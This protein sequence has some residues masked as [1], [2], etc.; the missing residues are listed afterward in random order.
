MAALPPD[1]DEQ[2]SLEQLSVDQPKK[3]DNPERFEEMQAPE[4]PD[5]PPRPS[6]DTLPV[7]ILELIT[8]E[9][10]WPKERTPLTLVNKRLHVTVQQILYKTIV[11]Q[12]G[13][14][15]SPVQIAELLRSFTNNPQLRSIVKEIN[16]MPCN[17]FFESSPNAKIPVAG[18]HEALDEII[19][20]VGRGEAET[21]AMRVVAKAGET[22]AIMPLLFTIL[23]NLETL[24][25]NGH[26]AA[27]Q[28]ALWAFILNCLETALRS[29]NP[30]AP[31]HPFASLKHVRLSLNYHWGHNDITMGFA[32]TFLSLFY[33]PRIETLTVHAPYGTPLE[34]PGTDHLVP[35]HLRT[36]QVEAYRNDG[37]GIVK[38]MLKACPGL[39]TLI[40]TVIWS[41]DD[42]EGFSL[43]EMSSVLHEAPGLSDRLVLK[44]DRSYGKGG[45]LFGPRLLH[46]QNPEDFVTGELTLA[47]LVHI[48]WLA[49]TWVH[50]FGL[51]PSEDL[52]LSPSTFPPDLE[53]LSIRATGLVTQEHLFWKLFDRVLAA[54]DFLD[55]CHVYAPKLREVA[56]GISVFAEHPLEDRIRRD[57]EHAGRAQ[58]VNIVFH[59]LCFTPLRS[60]PARGDDQ[61]LPEDWKWAVPSDDEEDEDE[62]EDGLEIDEVD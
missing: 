15:R 50:L 12:W 36:L 34:W 35:K 4:Q 47:P 62:D 11:L 21:A 45:S 59:P 8:N 40:W 16:I 46:I 1:R 60:V 33:L 53:R 28:D 58:G 9:L 17:P 25:L 41:E 52:Q 20:T 2:L 26:I 3:L 18:L 39:K 43:S 7:E 49:L 32:S 56:F 51:A 61:A 19:N 5:G 22:R 13:T 23:P 6:L 57:L 48:K 38:M 54:R 24:C 10:P 29:A 42:P 30:E 31:K 27:H 37:N 55:T 44:L 14:K